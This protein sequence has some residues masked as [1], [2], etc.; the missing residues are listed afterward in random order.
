M[1]TAVIDQ[2]QQLNLAYLMLAQQVIAEDRDTA[3]FKLKIDNDML[4]FIETLSV[5]QLAQ[6]ARTNQI[7]FRLNFESADQLRQ[8]TENPRDLGLSS[9]H[10]SLVLASKTINSTQGDMNV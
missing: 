10:A 8:I 3:P 4:Y 6:L 1:K 5:G 2:I 7:V 9:M